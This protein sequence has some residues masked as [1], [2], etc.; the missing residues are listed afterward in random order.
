MAIYP[1]TFNNRPY[2]LQNRFKN[3]SF[4]HSFLFLDD[5]LTPL[6]YN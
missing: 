4:N 6:K 5:A 3:Y 2:R 1:L